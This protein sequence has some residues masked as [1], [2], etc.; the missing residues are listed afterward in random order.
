MQPQPQNNDITPM[1]AVPKRALRKSAV[2]N[3]PA[4]WCGVP[5]TP[6]TSFA[7]APWCGV[8]NTPA[9]SFAPAP[10]CG[11]PNS[12]ARSF[13]PAPWCG[14]PNS[15]TSVVTSSLPQ[16]PTSVQSMQSM[17]SVRQTPFPAQPVPQT[18]VGAYIQLPP[19]GYI[20]ALAQNTD[21]AVPTR[22]RPTPSARPVAAA[23]NSAASA[24]ST[25]FV[26]HPVAPA[27]WHLHFP[28]LAPGQYIPMMLMEI[29]Q[30]AH[31]APAFF[32]QYISGFERS[33]IYQLRV[34]A[35]VQWFGTPS[36][37]TSV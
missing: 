5:N 2:S 24:S 36:V 26:Q 16:T 12:P 30:P 35:V 34:E 29:N 1:I 31:G 32:M 37:D 11:V 13:V 9:T 10:W 6:A 33:V 3:T 17:Q 28:P 14:V 22:S 25:S 4:L 20:A 8:P 15:P 23:E 7:P 18:H 19:V 21:I 27:N